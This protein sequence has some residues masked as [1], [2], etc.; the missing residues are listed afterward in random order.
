LFR[1]FE[2]SF[3]APGSLG[4]LSLN[5]FYSISYSVKTTVC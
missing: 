4:P 2:S 3:C 1:P 5:F